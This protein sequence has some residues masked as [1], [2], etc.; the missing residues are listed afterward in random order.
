MREDVGLDRRPRAVLVLRNGNEVA[1]EEDARDLVDGE[2]LLGQGRPQVLRVA[3]VEVE[4]CLLYTS[5]SPR[6]RG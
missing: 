1:R 3:P 5:P 6:D 2:E 4:A